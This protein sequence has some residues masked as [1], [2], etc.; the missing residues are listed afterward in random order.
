VC[1]THQA[2]L[3]LWQKDVKKDKISLSEHATIIYLFP[4]SMQCVFGMILV[5]IFPIRKYDNVH[6]REKVFPD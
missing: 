4:D 3:I 6:F 2:R 1:D 5:T